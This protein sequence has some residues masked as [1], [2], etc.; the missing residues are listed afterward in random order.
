MTAGRSI[1]FDRV[2]SLYRLI[3]SVNEP[4]YERLHTRTRLRVIAAHTRVQDKAREQA[5]RRV[6]F[7]QQPLRDEYSRVGIRV[8]RNILSTRGT[9][10]HY[11]EAQSLSNACAGDFHLGTPPAK[12]SQSQTNKKTG[13]NPRSKSKA[14]QERPAT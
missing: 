2:A 4:I 11:R 12:P 14:S 13:H 9:N 8:R 6:E 7:K 3:L 5:S 10:L 1:L